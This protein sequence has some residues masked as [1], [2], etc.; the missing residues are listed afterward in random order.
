[1]K[2]T[3]A[4]IEAAAKAYYESCL[5][6]SSIGLTW[7]ELPDDWQESK[8]RHT[9]AALEAALPMVPTLDE[10][11]ESF[12]PYSGVQVY[13]SGHVPNEDPYVAL[14]D[15]CDTE[16]NIRTKHWGTGP[17]REAALDAAI[18]KALEAKP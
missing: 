14:L 4:M 3:E 8:K 13:Y 10:R 9:R 6:R 1:M 2:P 5:D 7:R 15:V 18:A 12:G 16:N 17:T 11:L